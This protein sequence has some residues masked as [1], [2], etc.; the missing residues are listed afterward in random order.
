MQDMTITQEY[1]LCTL[2]EKGRISGYNLEGYVCLV[3]SGLLELMLEHIIKIEGKKITVLNELP[4]E[5]Q[6]LSKLYDRVSGQKTMSITKIAEEY[7][8]QLG[9]KRINEFIDDIADT[10]TKAGAVTEGRGGAM[11]KKRLYFPNTKSV[12]LIIDKLRSELL[13]DGEVS[14]ETAVLVILLERSN[15]LKTYFSKYEQKEIKQK[16]K[17]LLKTP[18]G[19]IVKEMA[20]YINTLVAVMASAGAFIG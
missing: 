5:K 8:Y 13:E 10:L 3:A 11:G 19:S 1:L 18:A 14:D 7:I 6:Y 16:M 9:D 15:G 12:G 4:S 17:E 20:D 2:N